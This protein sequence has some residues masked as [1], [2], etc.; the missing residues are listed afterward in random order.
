MSVFSEDGDFIGL[1]EDAEDIID[2]IN[3]NYNDYLK[4]N[5]MA[6][7]EAFQVMES[8]VGQLPENKIKEKLEQAINQRKPFRQFRNLLDDYPDVLKSWYAFKTQ[9]YM[10][11]VGEIVERY[12]ANESGK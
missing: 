7:S 6:S 1:E 11:Y 3:E 10:A 2:K 12:N 8:F 4:F 9:S 5:L